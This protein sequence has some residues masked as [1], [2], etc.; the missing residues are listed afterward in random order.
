MTHTPTPLCRITAIIFLLI[1]KRV[2]KSVVAKIRVN[3]LKCKAKV[4]DPHHRFP[5]ELL[6]P[7]YF[8]QIFLKGEVKSKCATVNHEA[9]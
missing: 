5:E 8:Y 9:A 2:T 3:I 1:I 4:N 6:F 7:S